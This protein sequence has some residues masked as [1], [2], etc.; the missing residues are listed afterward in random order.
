MITQ[1]ELVNTIVKTAV[2]TV[3]KCRSV[4]SENGYDLDAMSVDFSNVMGNEPDHVMMVA[5]K[6]A[7]MRTPAPMDAV[8]AVMYLRNR[9]PYGPMFSF[10]LVQ[11]LGER[12]V[13][14]DLIKELEQN[15]AKVIMLWGK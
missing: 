15:P 4:A 7:K 10:N 1:D 3:Q 2:T 5:E 13:D 14:S 9:L 11:A 8:N 6:W 12:G